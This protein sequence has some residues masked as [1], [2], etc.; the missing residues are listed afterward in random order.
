MSR[1][2][3]GTGFL[4]RFFIYVPNAMVPE[5]LEQVE[6]LARTNTQNFQFNKLY[7]ELGDL[8][9]NNSPIFYL[10]SEAKK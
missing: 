8:D 2:D 10:S 9:E 6:A 5:P 4:D 1:M 7:N 3:N